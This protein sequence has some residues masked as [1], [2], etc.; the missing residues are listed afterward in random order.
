MELSKIVE[1]MIKL[2]IERGE[3]DNLPGKG[4][5]IKLKPPNPFESKEENLFY[6]IL[7]SSGVMPVEILILKE[8]EV[9][10]QRLEECKNDSEKGVLKKKL[11]EL[12]L[13][14]DIQMDARRNF[15]NS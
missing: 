14:Y 3:F 9:T 13:K 11:K 4:K 6:K 1:T 2:A 5:Q 15:F 7:K 10:K 8:L 12:K